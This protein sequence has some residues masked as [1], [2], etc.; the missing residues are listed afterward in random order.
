MPA[1]IVLFVYNRPDHVRKTVDA[2]AVNDLA[3][4]SD[5]WIFSDGPRTPD[6]A[7]R[8]EEV[9]RYVGSISGTNL[10]RSTRVVE[11]RGNYGLARAI[12]S[13]VS[14]VLAEHE[15]AIVLEDDLLTAPDF[16][17][18]MNAG[19][20][21]YQ[22]E[23]GIGSITG[24][25]P[26]KNLPIDC[27]GSV[28]ILPRSCSYG[29]G[30]WRDRWT[31]VD[32]DVRDFPQ[33]KGDKKARRR[34]NA[35]GSD[36]YDMLRR[37]VEEGAESWSIRFGYWQFCEGL[38]TVY[39]VVSRVKNIGWD[40]TG[41]H[42]SANSGVALFNNE[43]SDAKVPFVFGTPAPDA[44]IIR[45]ARILYSGKWSTQFGQW[46]RCNELGLVDKAIKTLLNH[47]RLMG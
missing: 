2:L 23:N 20:D 34:F 29:W 33:I 38:F 28:Y 13:G 36:C 22:S 24:Y 26:L 12:I 15:R 39:P 21:Y 7:A 44:R 5:L 11:A 47:W 6:D 25:S 8:V 45:Q 30:T 19:L 10:F 3:R 40:G 31:K 46:L 18:F 35:C 37:Q 43:I 17:S 9:R 32:W 42:S 14:R 4:E 16:L 1:P 41:V 27:R